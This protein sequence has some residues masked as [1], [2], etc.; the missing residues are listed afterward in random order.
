VETGGFL[1]GERNDYL[2][3]AWIDIATPPPSDSYATETKF[4]CGTKGVKELNESIKLKY[5]NTV[6]AIGSW[7]TH[8]RSLPFPSNTDITGIGEILLQEDCNREKHILVIV[9]PL[10]DNKLQIG[11]YLFVKNNFHII[12]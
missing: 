1:F 8:P 7:H 2:K 10:T 12:E 4:I 11:A 9:Q 3:T 6:R 5:F